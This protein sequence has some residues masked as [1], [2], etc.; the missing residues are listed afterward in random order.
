MSRHLYKFA[1]AFFFVFG[2]HPTVNAQFG[3][4]GK[5]F[6]KGYN[7]VRKTLKKA[8]KDTRREAGK[9]IHNVAREVGN[10]AENVGKTIK[11]GGKNIEN[12]VLRVG[13]HTV[14]FGRAIGKYMERS[15]SGT[16]N[17]F[18]DA[19]KRVEEGKLADALFHLSLDPLRNT[20]KNAF[21][22]TQESGWVNSVGAIA[23]SAYGGAGGAAAYASWQTYRATDGNA[24]LALRAGIITGLTSFGT[25]GISKMPS[26]DKF[27]MIKKAVLSGAV[28]GLAVAASGG[29]ESDILE[30]FIL[31]GG[32]VIIQDGYRNSTGHELDARSSTSDP[33][34]AAPGTEGC[35]IVD[36]AHYIDENG[37]PR[38]NF[39]KLDPQASFVGQGYMPDPEKGFLMGEGRPK[40]TLAH[41]SSPLM[42]SVGKVP[43]FNAMALFH[44][45]W[46]LSWGMSDNLNKATIFPALVLTYYGTGESL[47]G[48][49][50]D[51]VID[52]SKTKDSE[53][54]LTR[55]DLALEPYLILAG[56]LDE[57][58]IGNE[59]DVNPDAVNRIDDFHVARTNLVAKGKQLIIRNITNDKIQ[60]VLVIGGISNEEKGDNEILLSSLT[61]EALELNGSS[62]VQAE[63]EDL[64]LISSTDPPLGPNN[65][66]EGLDIAYFKK[67]DILKFSD[68]DLDEDTRWDLEIIGAETRT[69]EDFKNQWNIDLKK[70]RYMYNLINKGN[71]QLPWGYY[72][73][74]RITE[75]GLPDIVDL[76]SKMGDENP[77]ESDSYLTVNGHNFPAEADLTG[78]VL[79]LI[80][81][82][83]SLSMMGVNIPNKDV[84]AT[85]TSDRFLKNCDSCFGIMLTDLNSSRNF[86]AT[87]GTFKRSDKAITFDIYVNEIATT[88]SDNQKK[89]RVKGRISLQE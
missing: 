14:D 65:L 26:G 23:A 15:V 51:L 21:K 85:V 57:G 58:L 86:I 39:S 19:G 54:K 9:T 36:R 78:N 16:V 10:G 66:D 12:E 50:T 43:G 18:A 49:I 27:E 8:E 81:E 40:Y 6:K 80:S 42:K 37:R 1:I 56:T 61:A 41:D 11:I 4:V 75:D 38:I 87:S 60:R 64:I 71:K 72:G 13:P 69:I 52:Q 73:F 59:F 55:N 46:V 53:K 32:F 31:A 22:A 5:A 28:G 35:K 62:I 67:N 63:P 17:V 45:N 29:D 25:D 70:G 2:L 47:T 74:F 68:L 77:I 88:P 34:C 33:Y 44:D 82:D 84:I 83:S 20:E 7:N 24:E 48:K 30:G 76:W 3:S 89:I 79:S